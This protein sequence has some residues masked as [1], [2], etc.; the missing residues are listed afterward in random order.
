MPDLKARLCEASYNQAK[1]K[2]ASAVF[3]LMG[4]MLAHVDYAD[5]MRVAASAG[6]LPQAT[7]DY[8]IGLSQL[9]YS[10]PSMAR[11]EAT[12]LV[13]LSAMALMLAAEE[14]G[15]G[16]CPMIGFDPSAYCTLLSLAERHVPLM[17]VVVGKPTGE[18][19]GRKPRLAVADVLRLNGAAF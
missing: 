18:A 14:R 13:G 4:D 9:F 5:R 15:W 1:I 6:H 12:R 10:N 11:D 19:G 17:V 3:V 2:D 7:A 8:L 16:S